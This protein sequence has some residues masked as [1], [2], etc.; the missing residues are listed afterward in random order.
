MSKL[1]DLLAKKKSVVPVLDLSKSI[2]QTKEEFKRLMEKVPDYK[3]RSIKVRADEIKFKEKDFSFKTPRK[4]VRKLMKHNGERAVIYTY[5]DPVPSEMKDVPIMDLCAVPIDWKML[6]TLRP[7]SR[8]EEEY[9]SRMTDMAKSQ[10]KTEM[11]DRREFMLNNCVKKAKNKSG[12]V[13]TRLAVCTECGQEMC[14]G[15]ACMDFN[16]DLFQRVEPKFAK[17]KPPTHNAN[18]GKLA[19]RKSFSKDGSKSKQRK[20]A[21]KGTV[22]SVQ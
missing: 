1:E 22:N 15:K 21:T 13:E 20:P 16:Y 10:L 5:A 2:V 3:M 6:T 12:I 19:G 9:F 17:P 14:S 7:K 8:L 18:K 4:E 11:R